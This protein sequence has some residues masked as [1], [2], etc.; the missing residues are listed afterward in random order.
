MAVMWEALR[1]RSSPEQPRNTNEIK[2]YRKPNEQQQ[3][4]NITPAPAL[5]EN[6]ALFR[7][8]GVNSSFSAAKTAK[9]AK[10]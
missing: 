9:S 6:G 7:G 1:C 10:R 3:Q 8:H 2:Q 4:R 5:F